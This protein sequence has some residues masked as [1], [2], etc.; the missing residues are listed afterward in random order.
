MSQISELFKGKSLADLSKNS[1]IV[2]AVKVEGNGRVSIYPTVKALM[3][4]RS[5]S[6]LEEVLTKLFAGEGGLDSLGFTV[7]E[8]K[9]QLVEDGIFKA[10]SKAT[11]SRNAL[12]NAQRSAWTEKED[13]LVFRTTGIKGLVYGM[14]D[15]SEF[16]ED[17]KDCLI[18]LFKALDIDFFYQPKDMIVGARYKNLLEVETSESEESKCEAP[19]VDDPN[20]EIP[21]TEELEVEQTIP[22]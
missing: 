8:M 13:H 14:I 4:S 10:D 2:K 20:A 11:K 19:M 16:D 3:L 22:A 12:R 21:A 17:D 6:N 1:H 7:K 5:K 18:E 9:G 15:C